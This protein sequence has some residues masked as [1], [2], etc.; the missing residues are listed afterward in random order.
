M[1]EETAILL[2]LCS[3]RR[4]VSDEVKQAVLAG[5][6]ARGLQFTVVLDCCGLVAASDPSLVALAKSARNI[7]VVACHPRAVKW[8]LDSA[9]LPHAQDRLKVLDMR[10]MTAEE[11]LSQ[12]PDHAP[13]AAAPAPTMDGPTD[14]WPAWFPVIDYDR[15]RHCKQCVSFCLFGVYAVSPE[16]KVVVANPRGCKDNCPACARICPEVAIMFPKL[17]EAEAPLNGDAIGDE[18]NLKARARVN[19]RELMGSDIY[20]A[21]AKRRTEAHKRRLKRPATEQAEAERAAHESQKPTPAL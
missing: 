14:D 12:F 8:L 18:V 20:A 17:P 11:I 10:A 15:C 6:R 13:A 9:G 4:V 7:T 3:S 21:L 5:L 16:G 1:S 2:C 19:A